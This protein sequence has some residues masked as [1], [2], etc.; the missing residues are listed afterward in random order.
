MAAIIAALGSVFPDTV[1]YLLWGG[2]RNKH[3]RKTSHW[4]IPYLAAFGVCFFVWGNG[5]LPSLNDVLHRRPQALWGCVSFWF[6]GGLAHILCDAFCGKVPLFNPRKKKFGIKVFEMS[7]T[8]GEMSSGEMVFTGFLAL[9]C[10]WAWLQ[11]FSLI[12]W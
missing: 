7:K 11:R 8:R 9:S 3:H 12:R 2:G 10:L 6:L 5:E 1:E 4:F